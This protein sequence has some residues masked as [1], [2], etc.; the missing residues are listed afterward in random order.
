M[1]E[2]GVFLQR[3]SIPSKQKNR[4]KIALPVQKLGLGVKKHPWLPLSGVKKGY[5]PNVS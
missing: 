3:A 4:I 2:N 5:R 1:K